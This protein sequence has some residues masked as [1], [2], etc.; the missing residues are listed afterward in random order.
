MYACSWNWRLLRDT[1]SVWGSHE[2]RNEVIENA[3]NSKKNKV[4]K[5]RQRKSVKTKF[6][7]LLADSMSNIKEFKK[8]GAMIFG[9]KQMKARRGWEHWTHSQTYADLHMYASWWRKGILAVAKAAANAAHEPVDRQ[10]RQLQ[11]RKISETKTNKCHA[12]RR[13]RIQTVPY[14]LLQV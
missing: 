10:A 2:K 13:R 11:E 8:Y 7:L 9:I 5:K 6:F 4:K 14:S 3:C 1:K 12:F